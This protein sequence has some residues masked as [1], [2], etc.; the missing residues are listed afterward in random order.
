MQKRVGIL[1][2]VL[3][4]TVLSLDAAPAHADPIGYRYTYSG[5]PFQ[6]VAGGACAGNCDLTIELTQ[7][8]LLPA[9]YSGSARS[10]G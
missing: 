4:A 7:M 1:A 3:A 5:N 2:G 9:N 10:S 8:A 6:T